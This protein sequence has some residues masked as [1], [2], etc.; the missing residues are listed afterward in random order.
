M[1][2]LSPSTVWLTLNEP[3][4]V[5]AGF[6][7]AYLLLAWGGVG[8]LVVDHGTLPVGVW[9][10]RMAAATA[11]LVGGLLAA[12]VA[13]RGIWWAERIALAVILL[14]V[15]ARVLAIFGMGDF[16]D[17]GHV[18][19]GVTAWA[20][21]GVLLLGRFMWVGVS[22]YRLGAGTLP[23]ELS[24]TLARAQVEKVERDHDDDA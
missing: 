3:R 7:A 5:T 18:V 16:R 13:W 4:V 2:R 9:S 24:A 12:P 22:P 15:A 23:A 14:G 11:F 6:V 1:P 17:E 20:V 19:F 10:G 8:G 21:V